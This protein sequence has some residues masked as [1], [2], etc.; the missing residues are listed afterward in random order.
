MVVIGGSK[1]K[2][3]QEVVAKPL[4]NPN[5]APAKPGAPTAQTPQQ[6]AKAMDKPASK[7]TSAK[8]PAESTAN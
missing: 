1:V 5:A 3:E 6:A 2:P 8:K 4:E 7:D